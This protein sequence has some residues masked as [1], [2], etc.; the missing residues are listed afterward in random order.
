MF[1]CHDRARFE[2]MAVSFG[3]ADL[4]PMRQRLEKA[5]D[6]FVD[7]CASSDTEVARMMWEGEVDIA[8][9]L[10]GPTLDARPGILVDGR[11]LSRQFISATLVAAGPPI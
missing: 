11:R 3:A 10:M 4:S 5:F 8:V 7:V 9:G 2:T 6:R 1:E